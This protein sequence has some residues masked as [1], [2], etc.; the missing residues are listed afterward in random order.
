MSDKTDNRLPEEIAS[1]IERTRADFS[2]TIDAIQSKLTPGELMDQAVDYA[3]TTTPGAFSANLVNT[4]RDNPIPV[5]LIGVGIAWL[6]TARRQSGA[7]FPHARNQRIARRTA[8]YP[9]AGTDYRG[10]PGVDYASRGGTEASSEGVLQRAASK[11]SDAARD[12]KHKASDVGQR[13]SD[14]ASAMTGRA[15]E[16]SE[17]ARERFEKSSEYTQARVSELGQRSQ[18]QY[19]RAKDRFGQLLDEQPLV[20]GAVGIA[21]GAALGASLPNTRRENELLG[22]TRDDLFERAKETTLAQT[23]VVKESAQRV[24]QAAR[25]EVERVK[26]D[27]TNTG[28]AMNQNSS[29][30]AAGIGTNTLGNSGTPG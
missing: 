16:I 9:D 22:N 11:T 1:D 25:Q 3:L 15:R 17:G 28:Q 20:V 19:Y 14:T 29:G 7:H 27:L 10:S 30:P 23:E 6:M 12:M 2:S 21:I 13:V 5:T 4:V 8:Y 26:E 24:A 18:A